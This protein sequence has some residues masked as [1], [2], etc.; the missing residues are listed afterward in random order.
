V[1]GNLL[2]GVKGGSGVTVVAAGL[3]VSLARQRSVLLAD[4]AG[5]QP[6][7]FGLTD[8]DRP[9]ISEWAAATEVREDSLARLCRPVAPN[10]DLLTRGALSIPVDTPVRLGAALDSDHRSLVIDAGVQP[11]G[12]DRQGASLTSVLVVRS[13]YLALR[14]VVRLEHPPDVVVLVAEPGR[15]LDR[16]DVERVV[17]APVVA[18]VEVDASVARR[19]D[20]GLLAHRLPP[21]LQRLG[22][23][24][25]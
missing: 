5:D 15:S 18:S 21:T 3:A 1:S 22:R 10:L 12:L 20:A 23:R 17:G 7:V 2:W 16:R 14:R 19:V 6:A 11:A 9:G 4:L 13:C 8:D 25:S 24:F